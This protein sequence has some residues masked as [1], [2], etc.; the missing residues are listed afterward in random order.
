MYSHYSSACNLFIKQDFVLYME[1]AAK[2]S[3]EFWWENAFVV[4]NIISIHNP[5]NSSQKDAKWNPRPVRTLPTA[6]SQNAK[7]DFFFKNFFEDNPSL[8]PALF[9]VFW[10]I[11]TQLYREATQLIFAVIIFWRMASEEH[12][13]SFFP[14]LLAQHQNRITVIFSKNFYF[15]FFHELGMKRFSLY[16]RKNKKKILFFSINFYNEK[17]VKFFFFFIEL[18]SL[19]KEIVYSC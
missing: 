16:T 1:H 17:I 18:N 12:L 11:F 8:I 7:N 15:S 13:L 9:E 6:N 19:E 4:R 14:A 5:S 10:K 3:T 2:Y